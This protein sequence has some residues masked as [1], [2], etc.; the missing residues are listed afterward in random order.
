MLN[1]FQ[2]MMMGLPGNPFGLQEDENTPSP[3]A[4]GGGAGAAAGGSVLPAVAAPMIDQYTNDDRQTVAF[5]KMGQ[6]GALLLAASQR[7]TPQMRGQ[8]LA[9]GANV[10][11]DTGQAM[12]NQAQA[13]LAGAKAQEAQL[14]ATRRDEF[15]RKVAADPSILKKLGVTPDQYEL[16][17]MDAVTKALE[18]QMSRDPSDIA[19]KNAMVKKLEQG[20]I[21]DWQQIGEDEFGNKQYGIPSQI[22]QRGGAPTAMP[23]SAGNN[24]I[25]AQLGS[26]TGQE[27]L[28]K[29]QEINPAIAGE[30]SSIVKGDQPFPP[31]MF[32]TK[33]GALLNALVTVVDPTYNSGTFK[34]RQ[35][36]LKDFDKNGG[37]NTAGGQESFG[38]VGIQHMGEIYDKAD[39]LPNHTNFGPLNSLANSVDAMYQQRTGKGGDINAYKLSVINGMDEI[40]KA[41]GIGGEG[42]RAELQHQ[43][44]TAQGPAAIKKAVRQQAVLLK[45][46]LDNLQRRWNSEMGPAAGNRRIISP[47]AEHVLNHILA[48]EQGKSSVHYDNQGNRIQ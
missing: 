44:E 43:L 2:R 42:G 21:N 48:D 23:S 45:D 34:H 31:R 4:S 29:L 1:Q 9:Q 15:R 41:L 32:G 40:A 13:R 38:N 22:M 30:V 6:M 19:Y 28:A 10:M 39:N 37:A 18:A 25:F 11:G 33:H 16:M 7:M 46:K 8:I 26:S 12:L 35:D 20:N 27:A 36:V 5:D 3:P 24:S 47:E 17:G 14:D